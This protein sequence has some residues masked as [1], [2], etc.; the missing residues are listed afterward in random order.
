MEG[1]R[2]AW[3]ESLLAAAKGRSEDDRRLAAAVAKARQHAAR[4]VPE[5]GVLDRYTRA[6]QLYG[7]GGAFAEAAEPATIDDAGESWRAAVRRCEE[8]LLTFRQQRAEAE[9]ARGKVVSRKPGDPV[10][11]ARFAEDLAVMRA[12]VEALQA[13]QAAEVTAARDHARRE[14]T[15]ESDRV[16]HERDVILANATQR[17]RTAIDQGLAIAGPAAMGWDE[18]LGGIG[19]QPQSGT[20]RWL[21]IGAYD[22]AVP[23]G[24][25]REVPCLVEFPFKRA[26][27]IRADATD[28]AQ[29]L[30]LAR[31]VILRA[32]CGM[33]AGRLTLTVVDPVALGGSVADFLR[34]GDF[35]ARLVDTKP[36]TTIQEIE[37]KLAELSA[38]LEVVISKRLR[39]QHASIAE[40][41]AV[42][43]DMAEPYKLL[44]VFDFPAQL[45]DQALA[46]LASII[47]NGPRCGVLTLLLLG[48]EHETAGHDRL[49][50]AADVVTWTGD[51]RIRLKSGS[52]SAGPEAIPDRCPDITFTP[53][54][55]PASAAAVALERIGTSTPVAHGSGPGGHAFISYAREDTP[56]ADRLHS[57]LEAAGVP[58]WRDTASLWPGEDWRSK[59]RSAITEDALVFIGCFSRASL[60]RLKTY[61]N[62][63]LTLAIEQL[64]LRNPGQPWLMPVRF[65]DCEIPDVIIGGG[66]TLGSIQRCDLFGERS[67]AELRRLTHVVQRILGNLG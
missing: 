44:A 67:D 64:R 33:P 34:L 65:D 2:R 31:S 4:F 16:R 42:A 35:A 10:L 20:A 49:L 24:S 51:G 39:G 8:N 14:I 37:W 32:L 58:V 6:W 17:A 3:Q 57:A 53:A 47:D 13:L 45:T 60:A 62:E 40:Y 66:R 23:S 30:A 61:Q 22:M 55:Q 11:P 50:A 12:A 28:Q 38:H 25:V 1:L 7:R 59:I 52:G 26:L 29:A 48:A 27:A 36:R 43:G 19:Q 54:G 56:H 9:A 5:Q 15:A 46:R 63:E 18:F 41:N 21:R